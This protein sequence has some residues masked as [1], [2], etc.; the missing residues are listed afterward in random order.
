MRKCP[1]NATI[2]R[3]MEKTKSAK[4]RECKIQDLMSTRSNCPD[5][6][7]GFQPSLA[8][9]PIELL[10]VEG[11]VPFGIWAAGVFSRHE[12]LI[13]TATRRTF[14]APIFLINGLTQ[15][16]PDSLSLQTNKPLFRQVKRAMSKI[17]SLVKR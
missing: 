10:V 5:M 8:P 11:R 15:R 14:P 6:L 16:N 2:K 12:E 1:K 13:R 7:P 4:Y 3:K 17:T 9:V